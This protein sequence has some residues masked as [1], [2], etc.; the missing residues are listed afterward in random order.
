MRTEL[1]LVSIGGEPCDQCGNEVDYSFKVKDG[2]IEQCAELISRLVFGAI[3][4][5][6]ISATKIP[7]KAEA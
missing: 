3:A 2:C 7:T 1:R 4:H 5:G 6:D